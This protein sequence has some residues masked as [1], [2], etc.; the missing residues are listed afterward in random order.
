MNKK[1]ELEETFEK[2]KRLFREGRGSLSPNLYR[3]RLPYAAIWKSRRVP[4]R[5]ITTM[6]TRPVGSTTPAYVP[7]PSTESSSSESPRPISRADV[8]PEGVTA[9]KPVS[10]SVNLDQ[11]AKL[12]DTV[13]YPKPARL[14]YN[15]LVAHF[16][17]RNPSDSA[18]PQFTKPLRIESPSDLIAANRPLTKPAE[19]QGVVSQAISSVGSWWSDVKGGTTE[20]LQRIGDIAGANETLTDGYAKFAAKTIAKSDDIALDLAKTRVPSALQLSKLG[21]GLAK[22]AGI[23]NTAFSVL[24]VAESY[25]KEGKFG[26]ETAITGLKAVG[27]TAASTVAGVAIGAGTAALAGLGGMTVLPIAVGVGATLGAGYAINK[28]YEWA[29]SPEGAEDFRRGLQ[30]IG[31]AASDA[32]NYVGDKVSDGARYAADKIS[33]GASAISG[34]FSTAGSYLS[35]LF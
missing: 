35:S 24:D 23:L 27:Q 31:N 8:V 25:S 22:G 6:E 1:S 30:V 26:R 7:K 32:A 18:Y 33:A 10:S 3:I 34:A 21:K 14:E 5:R 15:D 16:P 12:P 13:F 4:I 28:A 2:M 20:A 9:Q 11:L 29:A 17:P 19:E